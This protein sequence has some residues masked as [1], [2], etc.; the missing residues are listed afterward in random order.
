MNTQEM[1]QKAKENLRKVLQVS[2]KVLH[3]ALVVL[4]AGSGLLLCPMAPA[5]FML[6]IAAVL[7]PCAK[8]Q[9]LFGKSRVTKLIRTLLIIGLLV[10]CVASVELVSL[11]AM[12]AHPERYVVYWVG[13]IWGCLRGL[14]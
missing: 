6:G 3:I 8:V 4:F 2:K 10:G 7:L 1:I 12:E 5:F 9:A 14:F 13:Y 11:E